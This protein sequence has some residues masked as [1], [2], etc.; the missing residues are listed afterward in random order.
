MSRTLFGWLAGGLGLLLMT[1]PM[2]AHHNV[3]GKFDP[4]KTRTLKGVVTKLRT[5]TF[6]W[7]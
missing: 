4:G 2:P 6:S 5:F 1:A 3:T 7:T